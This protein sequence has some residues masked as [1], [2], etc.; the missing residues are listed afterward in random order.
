MVASPSHM[1]YAARLPAGRTFCERRAPF[2]F[3]APALCTGNRHSAA[4][5]SGTRLC[6]GGMFQRYQRTRT[7][8]Q[9]VWPPS[10]LELKS[11]PRFLILAC[12]DTK[13]REFPALL[14]SRRVFGP[15]GSDL[16]AGTCC[17]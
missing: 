3:G 5:I 14:W 9:Q 17:A 12:E 4:S 8:E 6:S 16:L 11:P 10:S 2:A 1:G 13:P 7:T 15:H